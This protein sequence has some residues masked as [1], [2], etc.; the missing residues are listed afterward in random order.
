MLLVPTV[1]NVKQTTI[2]AVSSKS[3]CMDDSD[4]S[5]LIVDTAESLVGKLE[6]G[7]VVSFDAAGLASVVTPPKPVAQQ[8]KRRQ[9]PMHRCN[10]DL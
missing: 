4:G 8:Q 9:T 7:T 5:L 10:H 1:D 6:T 3:V 2:R